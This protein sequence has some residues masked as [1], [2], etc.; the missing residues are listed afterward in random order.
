M[1]VQFYVED[2][3]VVLPVDA[4]WL[5]TYLEEVEGLTAD[6]THDHDDQWD[7][8]IDGINDTLVNGYSLLD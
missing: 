6:M 3:R 1:D 2:Q 8:T 5:L 7:P 4:P